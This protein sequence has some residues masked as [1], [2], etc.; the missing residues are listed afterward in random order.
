MGQNK[1]HLAQGV[2]VA[3]SGSK[4]YVVVKPDS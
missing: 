2:P 4:C 1:S 3:T